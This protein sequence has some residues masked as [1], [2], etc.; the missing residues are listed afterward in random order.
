M[1][2]QP[3]RITVANEGEITLPDKKEPIIPV[4]VELWNRYME[5]IKNTDAIIDK[6]AAFAW[7]CI[8][9]SSSA[10]LTAVTLPLS[11]N[12]HPNANGGSILPLV[13]EVAVSVFSLGS[14]LLGIALLYGARRH[15][16]T[17]DKLRQ[18]LVEDME[19]IK[20]RWIRIAPDTQEEA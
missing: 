7:S 18:W 16:A 10:T 1:P 12:L 3:G 5:R 11:V 14:L 2:K 15:A 4:S 17:N 13:V 20:T 6:T 8:G 9:F 19:S